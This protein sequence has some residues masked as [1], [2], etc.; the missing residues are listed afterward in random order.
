MDE[1]INGVQVIKMYAW[2]KPFT[3][4]ITLARKSELKIVMKSSYVRALFMTFNLF[5]TRAAMFSTLLT[6]AL[7]DQPITAAKVFVFMSYFNILSQTMSSMFVRGI[8]EVAELLVAIKRLQN[9]MMN[10][11]FKVSK[12]S[13]NNNESA[14]TKTVVSLKNLTAKWN[15]KSSEV[16]LNEININLNKGKLIGVI[17]PVGSGKSSLLQ[18]VLSKFLILIFYLDLTKLLLQRS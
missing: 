7:M 18:T 6:M 2:E 8:S 13:L 4:L 11:E 17:G 10:E 16:A 3:K 5:T 9:F 12:P 14:D 15:E 1:I